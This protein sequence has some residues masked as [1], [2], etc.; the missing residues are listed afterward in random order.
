MQR[1]YELV[2]ATKKGKRRKDSRENSKWTENER[3]LRE[4]KGGYRVW[5]KGRK[6]MRQEDAER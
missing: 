3:N 1:V 6:R 4:I 2:S 5:G